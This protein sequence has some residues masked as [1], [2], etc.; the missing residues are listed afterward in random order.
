[1]STKIIN[2]I[3]MD[4][5][6]YASIA[7]LTCTVILLVGLLIT[8]SQ[9]VFNANNDAIYVISMLIGLMLLAMLFNSIFIILF[10]FAMWEKNELDKNHYDIFNIMMMMN[11]V[12]IPIVLALFGIINTI[13]TEDKY[14][15]NTLSFNSRCISHAIEAAYYMTLLIFSVFGISLQITRTCT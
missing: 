8:N 13:R 6:Y 11:S 15:S 9:T 4:K 5:Q 1:M 12:F 3:D 2:K 10:T 7:Q 14:L